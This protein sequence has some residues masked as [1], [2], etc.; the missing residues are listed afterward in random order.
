M[1]ALAWIGLALCALASL[2]SLWYALAAARTVA[3]SDS[4]ALRST[5]A[6]LRAFAE[7]TRRDLED[8]RART[9]S[10]DAKLIAWRTDIE[11]LLE[12]VE[13]TLDRTE[14]KRRSAAASASRASRQD[15]EPQGPPTYE[16]LRERARSLGID[17]M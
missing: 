8:T 2:A 3:A 5:L 15:Q 1:P 9:D 13:D 17:V 11:G 12:A 16:N 14:R 6:D 4:N 7:A 10:Q